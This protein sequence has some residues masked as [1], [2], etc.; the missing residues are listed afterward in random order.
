M[1]ATKE[2]IDFYNVSF[3]RT[4]N[5]KGEVSLRD[6]KSDA[7][8]VSDTI[9]SFNGNV[10]LINDYLQRASASSDTMVM[11]I[12]YTILDKFY[13][14]NNKPL[15]TVLNNYSDHLQAIEKVNRPGHK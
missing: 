2:F 7:R 6:L 1:E 15:L 11:I 9:E 13:D 3:G 14:P 10:R 12:L 8:L 5:L 4:K